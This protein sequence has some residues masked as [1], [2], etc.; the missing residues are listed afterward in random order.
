[1]PEGRLTWHRGSILPYASLWHTVLR[2]CALN[3]LH[4]ADLPTTSAR[5]TPA[6]DLLDIQASKI[7]VAALARALGEPPSAFDWST[8]DALPAALRIALAVPQPRVCL[9]CLA[10]GYHSALFS[11]ALLDACPIHHTPLLGRCHC[12]APFNSAMRSLAD[13]GTAGSCQCGRLHFFTH[14]TCRQPTITADMTRALVPIVAWL[15]A[16]S[17]LIRPSRLDEALSEHAPGCLQWLINTAQSLGIDYPACLRHT[18]SMSAHIETVVYG[19]PSNAAL[20]RDRPPPVDVHKNGRSSLWQ[21]EPVIDMYRALARHIRRHVAPDGDLWVSRFMRS[22]DPIEIGELISS[23]GDAQKAFVAMLWARSVEPGVERRRWPYRLPSTG[24]SNSL[25]EIVAADCRLCGVEYADTETRH[26]LTCHAAR[27]SLGALWNHAQ[28]RATCAVCVR[29]AAWDKAS[30]GTSWR[31]SAWLALATPF[32]MQFA[33]P[34]FASW[35]IKPRASKTLRKA[36]NVAREQARHDAMWAAN[37]GACL[38]W[39]EG[40]S[41]HVIDAIAPVD[42]DVRHRRLLGWNDGHTWCWLYRTADGRFV[43]RWD[44]AALQVLA[45]TPGEALT[46]LRRCALE[47]RRICKVVLPIASPLS[48]AVPLPIE[49]PS[50]AN[51]Q[52]T[53]SAARCTEGFW[54]DARILAQAARKYRAS[55]ARHIGQQQ[56]EPSPV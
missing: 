50:A 24:L 43:A 40:D 18:L 32:S 9:A 2:A 48:I 29:L 26:W 21:T 3:A 54:R 35:P 36:A 14:E 44:D 49:T 47:Y 4:P 23:S 6:V 1:M 19:P 53:V 11:V 12:G 41:W 28:G 20:R 27:V 16:L 22:C 10:S 38:T 46:T 55:T 7:D 52:F 39:S 15:H 30:Q 45:A 56:A 31:D 37:K 17:Q 33:A 25:A 42:F 13:F 34:T 5:P 51:Y 8:L